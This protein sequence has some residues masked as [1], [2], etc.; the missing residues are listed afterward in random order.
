MQA[1]YAC[2]HAKPS[3]SFIDRLGINAQLALPLFPQPPLPLL[4][5]SIGNEHRSPS[6]DH[7]LPSSDNGAN[8]R[9]NLNAWLIWPPR[10]T[11]SPPQQ[12]EQ[13]VLFFLLEFLYLVCP[14]LCPLFLTSQLACIF[15]VSIKLDDP[16]F[17]VERV[18]WRPLRSHSARNQLHAFFPCKVRH[19]VN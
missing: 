11:L 7:D 2:M 3:Q 18:L 15:S 5:I 1:L 14:H 17:Y 9:H 4:L 12:H 13:A 16:E 8:Y 10:M 19:H 6:H